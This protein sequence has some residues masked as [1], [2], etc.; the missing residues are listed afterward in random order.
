MRLAQLMA[1]RKIG[2]VYGG[3]S[4]GIM[5]IIANAMLN[6][7]GE[8]IGVIPRALFKTEEGHEGITHLHVVTTMHERKARMAELS[9][10]FI[11]LPGGIGTLEEFFEVW[12]WAMLGIHAKPFGLLNVSGYF[13]QLLSFLDHAVDQ[14]F[15]HDAHRAMLVVESHP[16]I[17]LKRLVSY[18][19][20]RV[21][22]LLS[23][24]E[25]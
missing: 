16:Q 20:P 17:L 8:V 1:D 13:D 3:G 6:Y 23:L 12:T 11:A 5:G 18:Q 25:T 19:V 2:L 22:R 14:Q 24:K 4:V 21:D 9:D 7:G 10:G 15:V